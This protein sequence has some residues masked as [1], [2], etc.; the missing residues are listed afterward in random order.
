M[1]IGISDKLITD[2]KARAT[3]RRQQQDATEADAPFVISLKTTWGC[4]EVWS[5]QVRGFISRIVDYSKLKHWGCGRRPTSTLTITLILTPTPS[6]HPPSQTPSRRELPVNEKGV[7]ALPIRYLSGNFKRGAWFARLSFEKPAIDKIQ[8]WK[9]PSTSSSLSSNDSLPL[10]TNERPVL[11]LLVW[12][13]PSFAQDFSVLVMSCLSSSNWRANDVTLHDF[14]NADKRERRRRPTSI[15][16]EFKL[17]NQSLVIYLWGRARRREIYS[18]DKIQ[19]AHIVTQGTSLQISSWIL[20]T[21]RQDH[22]LRVLGWIERV[23]Q[24]KRSSTELNPFSFLFLA[25]LHRHPL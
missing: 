18:S 2:A 12:S 13:H 6:S 21:L 16:S 17:S 8:K 24:L 5:T 25:M 3:E 11:H 4:D 1:G 10:L 14:G 9:E 20:Y 23:R 15:L 19:S 22:L 7:I